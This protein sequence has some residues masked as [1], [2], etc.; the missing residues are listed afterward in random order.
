MH[1][2]VE[3]SKPQE[4][5]E[6][7]PKDFS[8]IVLCVPD[9]LRRSTMTQTKPSLIYIN[10]RSTPN[11]SAVFMGGALVDIDPTMDPV[12][13]IDYQDEIPFDE[14][15]A[16]LKQQTNVTAANRIWTVTVMSVGDEYEPDIVFVCLGGAVI[17]AASFC[18]AIWIWSAA[19]RAEQYNEVVDAAERSNAIVTSLFPKN[20]AKQIM[21][22]NENDKNNEKSDT[23]SKPIADLFPE[24]TVVSKNPI[25]VLLRISWKHVG[26][27]VA[28]LCSNRSCSSTDVCRP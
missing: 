26:I 10:D 12:A 1:P 5:D 11:E 7:W 27:A 14:L 17:F 22:Y 18:L 20:V 6:V 2:G 4:T 3:L 13:T 24:T 19:R 25:R 28:D 21:E 15:S 8:S 23:K 9:L 16:D